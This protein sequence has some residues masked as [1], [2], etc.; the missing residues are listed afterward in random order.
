VPSTGSKGP[1][2]RALACP[3]TALVVPEKQLFGRAEAISQIVWQKRLIL[4]PESFP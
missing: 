3:K 2:R 1:F 4:E